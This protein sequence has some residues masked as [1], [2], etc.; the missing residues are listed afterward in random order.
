[1]KVKI[2]R[3]SGTIA[4]DFD[5]PARF[6][7]FVVSDSTETTFWELK[8]SYMQPAPIIDSDI[9]GFSVAGQSNAAEPVSDPQES[10]VP[11]VS[12]VI[13]GSTPEGYREI[14]KARPLK[15]GQR[16]ALVFFDDGN[17][18]GGVQFT[19]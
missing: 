15:S 9:I 16:Y 12:R 1:M 2:S 18:S 10:D 5:K 13:Y 14:T 6:D 7:V 11:A 8:P 3:V 4:F 17:D 19:A